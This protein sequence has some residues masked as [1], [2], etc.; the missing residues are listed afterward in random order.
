MQNHLL[1]IKLQNCSINNLLL[2]VVKVQTID[3][4]VNLRRRV[5][6]H[7][8]VLEWLRANHG[9]ALRG[10][11]CCYWWL[12]MRYL[13]QK[14]KMME[15]KLPVPPYSSILLVGFIAGEKEPG[16]NSRGSV[17]HTQHR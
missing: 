14:A 8:A 12:L 1:F 5:L 15:G 13:H 16:G 7:A 10:R 3:H 11:N 17:K 4:S 2:S 6:R 9:I